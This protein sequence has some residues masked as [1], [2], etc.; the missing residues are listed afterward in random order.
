MAI[1]VQPLAPPRAAAIDILQASPV[2]GVLVPIAH[3]VAPVPPDRQGYFVVSPAPPGPP[4]SA[5]LRVW[6]ETELLDQALRPAVQA[7]GALQGRGVTHRAIRL[8]NVFQAAPGQRIV[9]GAA[10]AAPPASLQPA[11]YEPPYSAMCLPAGRG[12]GTMADDIYAL[13]VL[14]L[15]LALGREPLSGL[16]DAAIMERKVTLGSFAALAG[17]DRLHPMIADLIRGM[18]AEDP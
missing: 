6:S 4:L 13:G 17:N 11:L 7:L 18:L 2:D 10:W 1:A 3:G 16:D 12:D 9:L 8:G 15:T 14:L 5:R